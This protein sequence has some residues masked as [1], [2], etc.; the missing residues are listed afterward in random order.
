MLSQRDIRDFDRVVCS[1]NF[2]CTG[3]TVVPAWSRLIP[4]AVVCTDPVRV[5]TRHKLQ[6]G[7]N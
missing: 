7:Q 1:V 4:A 2:V 5:V 6:G 3:A